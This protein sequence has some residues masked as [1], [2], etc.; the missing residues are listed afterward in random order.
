MVVVIPKPRVVQQKDEAYRNPY[1][2]LCFHA[3]NITAGTAVW[4]F[5]SGGL[6]PGSE[7][8]LKLSDVNL[9]CGDIFIVIKASTQQGAHWLIGCAFV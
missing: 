8:P 7:N 2:I 5:V 4:V 9:S 6:Q 3:V 1:F